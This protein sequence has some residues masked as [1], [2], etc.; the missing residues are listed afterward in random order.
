LGYC[1]EPFA[2]EEITFCH[3]AL[4][5]KVLLLEKWPMT[6]ALL[7]QVSLAVLRL[8]KCLPLHGMPDQEPVLLV[9]IIFVPFRV[10]DVFTE[11]F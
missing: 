6:A 4:K 3:T 9:T 11:F 1:V 5:R 10:T 7:C 8:I 2:G